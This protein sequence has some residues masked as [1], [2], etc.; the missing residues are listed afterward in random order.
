LSLNIARSSGSQSL[1][2]ERNETDDEKR[3]IEVIGLPSLQVT[4]TTTVSST[5]SHEPESPSLQSSKPQPKPDAT[6]LLATA[7][8]NDTLLCRSEPQPTPEANTL[9]AALMQS[10]LS[11]QSRE[12][13]TETER[14]IQPS[15]LLRDR[16]T[17]L[18]DRPAQS[19]IEER[20]LKYRQEVTTAWLDHC[21][22]NKASQDGTTSP[23]SS[24][25][26]KETF[27]AVASIYH[28]PQ[29]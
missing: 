15:P 28:K 29:R 10:D 18:R 1:E 9:L 13:Q 27:S 22:E 16:P 6:S 4:V 12:L 24:V 25:A 3:Q 2:T 21:H 11:F 23:T 14:R 7:M 17:M 20:E 26:T 8:P 5:Q 19:S